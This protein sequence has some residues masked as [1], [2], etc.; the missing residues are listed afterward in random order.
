MQ[1]VQVANVR[2]HGTHQGEERAQTE[3]DEGRGQQDEEGIGLAVAEPFQKVAEHG[4]SRA[5]EE[6]LLFPDPRAEPGGQKDHAEGADCAKCA[7]PPHELRPEVFVPAI[8]IINDDIRGER[9]DQH[10]TVENEKGC[11]AQKEERT[12]PHRGGEA[13]EKVG[14]RP[15]EPARG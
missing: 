7:V 3:R 5:E 4:K 14:N 8:N 10:E 9:G 13:A 2:H 15:P 12:E 6:G 1:L 11:A